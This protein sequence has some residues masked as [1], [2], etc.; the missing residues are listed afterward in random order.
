MQDLAIPFRLTASGHP[1]MVDQD[2]ADW[3]VQVVADLVATRPGERP[4]VPTYGVEDPTFAGL[5]L[6]TVS[7]ALSI[8]APGIEVS[9]VNVSTANRTA[10]YSIEVA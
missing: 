5:D 6:G 4:M 9:E 3:R 8:W 10:R 7:S 2:T 1:V